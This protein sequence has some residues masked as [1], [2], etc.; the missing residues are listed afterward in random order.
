MVRVIAVG[1]LVGVTVGISIGMMA[2]SLQQV[3]I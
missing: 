2:Q 1:C 3:W